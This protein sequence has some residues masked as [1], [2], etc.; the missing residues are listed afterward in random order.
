MKSTVFFV[1]LQFILGLGFAVAGIFLFDEYDTLSL[2]DSILLS[3]IIGFFCIL[4]GVGLAGYFHLKVKHIVQWFGYA[5]L[6]SFAGFVVFLILYV[7]IEKFLPSELGILS[8]FIP[9]TGA[10]FGFNLV[11][12]KATNREQST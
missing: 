4:A 2:N 1:I 12:A 5:M 6:L 9:L 10:V 7:F 8:L 11:A 3:F